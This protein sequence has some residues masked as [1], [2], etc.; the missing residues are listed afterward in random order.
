MSSARTAAVAA[1]TVLAGLAA[2]AVPAA[3]H[4]SISI[5]VKPNAVNYRGPAP[6]ATK[7]KGRLSSGKRHVKVTLEATGWPFTA[8]FHPVAHQRTGK[9]G[10]YSFKQRP[11]LA[12]E[13]RVSAAGAQSGT[14][15]VYVTHGFA[16]LSCKI[17]G[18]GKS[19]PCGSNVRIPP[20]TYRYRFSFD[21]LFP[22]SAFPLEKGK[23]VFVYYGQRN[24]QQKPPSTLTLQ[25]TV[26]QHARSGNTTHVSVTP[27]FTVPNSA[28]AFQL[29]VCTQTTEPTD[30]LGLPGAP[31]SHHCGSPSIT[32]RQSTGSLG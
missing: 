20:G 26:A 14:Q 8:P 31:G 1:A 3:G 2:G 18:Q 7:I 23:R 17:T 29:S 5:K 22:A 30:G 25:G 10:A 24:G 28:W 13:Y 19:Y 6:T 16:H 11:S 21:Y 15:T 9:H 12:T 32:Y 4:P 27:Q